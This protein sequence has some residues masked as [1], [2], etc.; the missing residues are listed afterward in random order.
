LKLNFGWKLHPVIYP[1]VK[2]LLAGVLHELPPLAVDTAASETVR[3]ALLPQAG[4][5]ISAS[6]LRLI[7]S[8]FLP[9]SL[10]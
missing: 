2:P 6:G 3:T 1:Q 9:H 7:F 5:A 4:Q 8:T 10:H